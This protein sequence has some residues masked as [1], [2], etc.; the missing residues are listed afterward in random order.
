MS[1]FAGL[2]EGVL[3]PRGRRARSLGRARALEKFFPAPVWEKRRRT[4]EGDACEWAW[5]GGGIP[6]E[7]GGCED[8]GEAAKERRACAA[9][10]GRGRRLSEEQFDFSA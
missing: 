8:T 7:K 9:W 10:G 6:Q 2:G 3:G 5:A 1:T 4:G